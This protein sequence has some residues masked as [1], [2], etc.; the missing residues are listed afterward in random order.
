MDAKPG[1]ALPCPRLLI[2]RHPLF[3][4]HRTKSVAF[5]GGHTAFTPVRE[6]RGRDWSWGSMPQMKNVL[7]CQVA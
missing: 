6:L 1:A 2:L 5:S 7:G 4:S 3:F